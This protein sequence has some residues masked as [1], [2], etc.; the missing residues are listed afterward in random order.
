MDSEVPAA[1]LAMIVFKNGLLVSYCF[2]FE[3]TAQLCIWSKPN[4]PNCIQDQNNPFYNQEF[5]TAVLSFYGLDHNGQRCQD[6]L[7]H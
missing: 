3:I 2:Y 1:P 6:F 4:W 7:K 5:T